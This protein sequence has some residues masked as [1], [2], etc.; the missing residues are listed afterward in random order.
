ML[1]CII[2]LWFN[3]ICLTLPRKYS[4]CSMLR[5]WTCKSSVIRLRQTVLWIQ[6]HLLKHRT[7]KLYLQNSLSPLYRIK[8]LIYSKTNGFTHAWKTFR[9]TLSSTLATPENTPRLGFH[10]LHDT[11]KNRIIVSI[12]FLLTEK[13]KYKINRKAA[14]SHMCVS[15]EGP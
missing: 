4:V 5:N 6:T 10:R 9:S 2:I 14:A 12:F 3:C 8:C 11:E 1:I 7:W 13:V 15:F